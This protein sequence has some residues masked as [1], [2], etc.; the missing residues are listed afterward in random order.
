MHRKSTSLHIA[1][2]GGAARLL[3]GAVD[4]N[5]HDVNGFDELLSPVI[6]SKNFS[7]I[8]WAV[9]QNDFYKSIFSLEHIYVN[10]FQGTIAQC[11]MFQDLIASQVK[12][13]LYH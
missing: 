1:A 7:Y 5:L 10:S 4:F 11:E 12:L 8:R 13:L 3:D 2:K 6:S 9:L